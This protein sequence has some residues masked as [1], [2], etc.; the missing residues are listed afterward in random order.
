[1]LCE[2][3]QGY[4]RHTINQCFYFL[5]KYGMYQYQRV[6]RRMPRVPVELEFSFAR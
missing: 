4:G 2:D 5:N 6:V 1:M 3:L